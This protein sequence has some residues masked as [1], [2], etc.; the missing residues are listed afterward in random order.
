VAPE[1]L[2]KS[3]P[4]SFMSGRRPA[5]LPAKTG[6]MTPRQLGPSRSDAVLLS[7]LGQPLLFPPASLVYF[8]E[9]RTE[10]DDVFDAQFGKLCDG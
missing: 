10:Y 4:R 1:P 2:I 7:N 6:D 3:I 8:T 5:N 9:P